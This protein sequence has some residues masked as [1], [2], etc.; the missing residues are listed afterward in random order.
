M[1][2]ILIIEDE[3]VFLK[4]LTSELTAKGYTV[5]QATDGKK[6]LEKAKNE[7]PDLILLDI[8]MPVMDGMTMLGLLR[9]EE[10]FKKT[11]VI[12][13]TNIEPDEDMTEKVIQGLP[14]YFFIKSDIKLTDLL[15]KIKK[16]LQ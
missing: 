10:L 3:L 15:A 14:L 4:L 8:K 11:K 16:V 13:L 9:Q 12:L 6:G 5:I 7:K 1:K 2:K